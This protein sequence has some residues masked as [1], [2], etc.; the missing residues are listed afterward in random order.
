MNLAQQTMSLHR[1]LLLMLLK[2]QTRSS[3]VQMLQSCATVVNY[4][5][6][7]RQKTKDTSTSK[8]FV[9]QATIH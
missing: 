1:L 5:E 4:A 6:N 8:I 3:R 7:Q 2:V 9:H